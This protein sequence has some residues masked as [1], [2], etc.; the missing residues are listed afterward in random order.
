MGHISDFKRIYS[1]MLWGSAFRGRGYICLTK[2]T[3]I[4]DGIT[5]ELKVG[6]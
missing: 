2:L 5:L 3:D 4:V 1:L 6:L